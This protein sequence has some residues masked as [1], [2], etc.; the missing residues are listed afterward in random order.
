ML[1]RPLILLLAI[2]GDV[3]SKQEYAAPYMHCSVMLCM[4][5]HPACQPLSCLVCAGVAAWMLR[6]AD[7]L[8]HKDAMQCNSP[9]AMHS[10]VSSHLTCSTVRMAHWPQVNLPMQVQCLLKIPAS[11]GCTMSSV[12]SPSPFPTSRLCLRVSRTSSHTWCARTHASA[13]HCPKS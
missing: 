12:H 10:N 3:F 11:W 9:T 1:F 6:F 7:H 4:A 5:S 13:S 8:L 2:V